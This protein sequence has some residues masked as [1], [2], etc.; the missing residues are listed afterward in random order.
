M[1][2][3]SGAFRFRFHRFTYAHRTTD[4][5]RDF[6]EAKSTTSFIAAV[7]VELLMVGFVSTSFRSVLFSSCDDISRTTGFI[8]V[9]RYMFEYFE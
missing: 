7:T 6:R 5:V 8:C 9:Q 3:G 4:F 1:D 2:D